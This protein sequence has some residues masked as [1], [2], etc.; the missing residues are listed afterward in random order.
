MMTIIL[1]R[2]VKRPEDL[3]VGFMR[4]GFHH[5]EA[6]QAWKELLEEIEAILEGNDI[7]SRP[8]TGKGCCLTC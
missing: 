5:A 1:K 6:S 7:S 3:I 2:F 8:E 4:L